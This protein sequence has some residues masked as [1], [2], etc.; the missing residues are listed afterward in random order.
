[1]QNPPKKSQL[2]TAKLRSSP[3]VKHK[4]IRKRK[5]I[6]R[7]AATGKTVRDEEEG[8]TMTVEDQNKRRPYKPVM[9]KFVAALAAK[10]LSFIFSANCLRF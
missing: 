5:E 1:M 3:Q 7:R 10:R 6:I 4:S 9:E 2:S 8:I